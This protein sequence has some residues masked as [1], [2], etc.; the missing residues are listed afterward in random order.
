MNE[1]TDNVEMLKEESAKQ[2][3]NNEQHDIQVEVGARIL[4]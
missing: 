2:D 4:K 1:I 3:E